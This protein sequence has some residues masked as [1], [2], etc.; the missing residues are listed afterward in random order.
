MG[1]NWGVNKSLWQSIKPPLI[2]SAEDASLMWSA[3]PAELLARDHARVLVLGVT[4]ALVNMPWPAGF[5]IC[6]VDFDPAMIETL[7]VDGQDARSSVICA[8]WSAMP[9]PDDH[10]DLVVGDCSFCAL[11]GL[12]AYQA[13]LSEIVRVKRDDA[14][15]ICRFFMQSTPR[16]TMHSVVEK[17]GDPL[18]S[19]CAPAARRLLIP[20]AVSGEDAAVTYNCVEDRIACEWGP[21]DAFLAAMGLDGE[22]EARSRLAFSLPHRLNFP[23]L[24]QI[25]RQFAAAGLTPTVHVPGYPAG[26]FCPTI[27]FD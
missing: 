10:F 5:E 25:T 26:Q 13:V 22:E 11:P 20:I 12:D 19:Q 21:F 8:N 18:L 2:P 6:A 1:S 3:C 14:P 27:R 7:W 24:A 16:L 15:I 23:T 9:F 4:P 17:L